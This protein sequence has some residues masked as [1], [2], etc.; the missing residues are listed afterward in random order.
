MKATEAVQLSHATI[1]RLTV[2]D[3]A[4]G[5]SGYFA[6]FHI[7]RAPA[8]GNSSSGMPGAERRASRNAQFY[9]LA[10]P[11][12]GPVSKSGDAAFGWRIFQAVVPDRLFSA[13]TQDARLPFDRAGSIYQRRRPR[14]PAAG[15]ARPGPRWPGEP[16]P[17]VTCSRGASWPLPTS[18]SCAW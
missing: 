6:D 12:I 15:R 9:P 3:T 18:L 8:P 10:R 17:D 4:I 1:L 16:G 11:G 13:L 7:S 14:D 5:A 2:T